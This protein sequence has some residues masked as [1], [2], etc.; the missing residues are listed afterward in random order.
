ML[1]SI[2]RTIIIYGLVVIVMRLMG[3]RQIGQLQPFEFVV[4]LMISELASIPMQDTDIPLMRGITPIIVL[5]TAQVVISYLSLK[6][7]PLRNIICGNPSI[8]I[9]NGK[10][11]EKELWRLGYSLNDLLEQLRVKNYPN[12]NEIEFA[13]L[14]TNGEI[15]VIPKAENTLPTIKDLNIKPPEPKLPVTLVLDGVT[16]NQ[17]L[18][19]MNLTEEWLLDQLKMFNITRTKDAL[20]ALLD[21]S[22]NFFAQTKYKTKKT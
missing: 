2:V 20:I 13:F 4:T 22:G 15:S 18:E 19:S 5:L 16:Q 10:I 9:K 3:K 8:V 14:E 11:Q 6:Y 17:N 21:T 12:L 1:I 7:Q